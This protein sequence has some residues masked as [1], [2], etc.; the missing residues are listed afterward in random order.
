[1]AATAA[2]RLKVILFATATPC[3]ASTAPSANRA[4]CTGAE[5]PPSVYRYP[6]TDPETFARLSA[7]LVGRYADKLAAYEIWNEPDQVNEN[8]WAGPDKVRRYVAMVQ[9]AYGPVKAAAP[10]VPVLAGSFV[11]AN[12]AWLQAM[13]DAGIKGSYDGLAVHFYDLPLY[14]LR[15]TREVQRRNGDTTPQWLTE[16]G[17]DSCYSKGGPLVRVQHPCMTATGQATALHDLVRA[18]HATPWIK[19]AVLYQLRDENADYRFGLIDGQGRPK[20]A[21]GLLQR[22]LH[23]RSIGALP[24]PTLSVGLRGRRLVVHG[25][26]SVADIYGLSVEQGTALRYRANLR[27]DRFARFTLTLPRGVPT[28]GIRVTLRSHWSRGSVSVSR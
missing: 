27:T 2:R 5:T 9:A 22:L 20:P 11:G 8:Y 12:G 14:A 19:A 21:L 13:Y 25:T 3:W 4:E 6:P 18:V 24:R 10:G 1:M 16:F 15:N 26:A 17:W 23:G 28:S 7:F